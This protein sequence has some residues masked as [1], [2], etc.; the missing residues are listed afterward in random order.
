[1]C[2]CLHV[3]STY[4]NACICDDDDDND[5]DDDGD[6]LYSVFIR[7]FI[8]ICLMRLSHTSATVKHPASHN[9]PRRVALQELRRLFQTTT[10]PVLVN[11]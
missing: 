4:S 5:D 10:S 8:I 9:S 1:M 11:K 3:R 6:F 7:W 2:I